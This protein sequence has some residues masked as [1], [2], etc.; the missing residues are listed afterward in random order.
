[1]S[2]QYFY[3]NLG[4]W[5]IASTVMYGNNTHLNDAHRTKLSSVPHVPTSKVIGMV[6]RCGDSEG[7][8]EQVLP[9]TQRSYL[10]TYY[11]Y[12][13]RRTTQTRITEVGVRWVKRNKQDNLYYWNNI[14]NLDVNLET[15]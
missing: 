4:R 5:Y 8:I 10:D 12:L 9:T 7:V 11:P 2:N 3:Q 14:N 6:V 1:M 15:L 13:V